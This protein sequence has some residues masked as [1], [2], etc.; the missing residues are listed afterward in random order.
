MG[1]RGVGHKGS[2]NEWS[3]KFH[4]G[5]HN[6]VLEGDLNDVL[7]EDDRKREFN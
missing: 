6:N 5:E 1:K 2:H 7:K 3:S 4:K